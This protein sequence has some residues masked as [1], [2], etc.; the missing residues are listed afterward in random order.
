MMGLCRPKAD[1]IGVAVQESTLIFL[2]ST[3]PF[4]EKAS[5]AST[6]RLFLL[7]RV[8]RESILIRSRIVEKVHE[9]PGDLPEPD[10]VEANISGY[11]VKKKVWAGKSDLKKWAE[12]VILSVVPS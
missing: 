2:P 5:P 10:E 4:G 7:S 6:R 8:S 1:S 12:G 3:W 11:W 9:K